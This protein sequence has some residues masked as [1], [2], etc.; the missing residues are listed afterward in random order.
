MTERSL[1]GRITTNS[2]TGAPTIDLEGL[3][4]D[5]YRARITGNQTGTYRIVSQLSDAVTG[6]RDLAGTTTA[7]LDLSGLSANTNYWVEVRS[8]N[9]VPTRYD[10]SLLL[11][12]ADVSEVRLGRSDTVVRRD[13]ILGGSGNDV[14]SGGSGEDWIFGQA[15]NDVLTGGLDR[16]ASDLL[17]GGAGNDTFQLIPDWL[18]VVP[19]TS[20][21]VNLTSTDLYDGGIG[22]DSVLFLGGD[23]DRNGNPVPDFAALGYN[24]TL[25]RYELTTKVWDVAN[26]QF[27]VDAAGIE[28]QQF[29]NYE[30]R[31]VERAVFDTRAGADEV[32]MDPK[33]LLAG[34]EY[35][36]G[37]KRG[38]LPNVE[39]RGGPVTIS[40][41][42][43]VV[44]I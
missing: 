24:T 20:Q 44:M 36:L 41:T 12:G 43:A 30:V 23:L 6:T 18:P 7:A 25:E 4:A 19:G 22:I 34:K 29:L 13:V 26:Q 16:Q 27:A 31:N 10:L 11:P 21:T 40:F 2:T 35:G 37:E 32:R 33:F 3:T 28:L 1:T 8:Q 42:A 39:L 15:G 9:L 17:F 38:P 14:L 5:D